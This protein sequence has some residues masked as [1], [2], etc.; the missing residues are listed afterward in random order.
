MFEIVARYFN[1]DYFG[2]VR[3]PGTKD[4]ALF[5]TE[6]DAS[7]YARKVGVPP[8]VVLQVQPATR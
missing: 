4:I 5:D 3:V 1:G 7:V 8:T 6:A 2:H